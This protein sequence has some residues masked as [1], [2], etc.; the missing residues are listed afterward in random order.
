MINNLGWRE[1]YLKRRLKNWTFETVDISVITKY[2]A[3]P[4]LS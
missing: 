1:A 2:G 4:H 3:P